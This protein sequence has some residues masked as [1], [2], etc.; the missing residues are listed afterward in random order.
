[1]LTNLSYSAMLG[2][3]LAVIM[4]GPGCLFNTDKSDERVWMSIAPIQCGGNAWETEDQS[5][6][7]YLADRGAEVFDLKTSS[8]A[9]AVCAACSC[10]TGERVDVLVDSDDVDIL[11][12]EGFQRFEDWPY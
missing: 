8:W 5:I 7:D 12:A 3:L 2:I 9:G 6:R 10:P 11:L 4:N 1:M